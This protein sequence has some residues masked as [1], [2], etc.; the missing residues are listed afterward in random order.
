M[1]KL[2]TFHDDSVDVH[3]CSCYLTLF[4]VLI[5]YLS[6]CSYTTH[7]PRDLQRLV[8]SVGNK[9]EVYRTRSVIKCKRLDTAGNRWPGSSERS[10]VCNLAFAH[11]CQRVWDDILKYGRSVDEH[12]VDVHICSCSMVALTATIP[13]TT[14]MME[15]FHMAEAATCFP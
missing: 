6:G 3:V 1:H 12:S 8:H 11:G 15:W 2:A 7:L 9:E 4:G 5:V 14:T 13:A 10:V